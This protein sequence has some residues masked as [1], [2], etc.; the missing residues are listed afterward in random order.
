MSIFAIAAFDAIDA[1]TGTYARLW[2]FYVLHLVYRALKGPDS[3]LSEAIF[4]YFSGPPGYMCDST[5]TE[6]HIIV[7]VATLLLAAV[8]LPMF[9]LLGPMWYIEGGLFRM[10]DLVVDLVVR[11]WSIIRNRL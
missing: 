2:I 11:A 6:P 7:K 3:L 1:Y 5:F 10:M 9:F 4:R 8:L